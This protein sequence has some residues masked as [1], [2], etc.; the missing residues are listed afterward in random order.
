MLCCNLLFSG[1]DRDVKV[2]KCGVCAFNSH[3]FCEARLGQEERDEA[4]PL[5]T[6]RRC[7]AEAADPAASPDQLGTSILNQLR[8]EV[9]NEIMDNLEKQR[10][11]GVKVEL[12][13]RAVEEVEEEKRKDMGHYEKRFE[14]ALTKDVMAFRQTDSGQDGQGSVPPPGHDAFQNKLLMDPSVKGTAYEI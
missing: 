1:F 12:L 3:S 2:V 6:C 11:L 10:L 13:G 5:L 7:E 14:D 8:Q 9:E 4:A